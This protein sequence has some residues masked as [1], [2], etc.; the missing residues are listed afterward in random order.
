MEDKPN[1]GLL[2]LHR[3]VVQHL[4]RRSAP[5]SDKNKKAGPSPAFCITALLYGLHHPYGAIPSSFS[6]SATASRVL[7]AVSETR[8][9]E[10]IPCSTRKVAK[11]GKSEG[12]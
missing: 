3:F 6:F 9:M 7:T 11:S 12:A 8:L 4:T 2:L 5:F 10:S 1:G